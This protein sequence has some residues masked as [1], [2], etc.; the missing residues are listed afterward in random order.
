MIVFLSR[1]PHA[2]ADCRASELLDHVLFVQLANIETAKR[3]NRLFDAL[4]Q[5][6]AALKEL[7][8]EVSHSIPHT[9]L[10]LPVHQLTGAHH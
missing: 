8:Q 4:K 9:S 7:Q 10:C 3:Q 1:V 6:Q 2:S 5:G